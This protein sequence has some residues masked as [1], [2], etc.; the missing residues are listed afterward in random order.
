LLAAIEAVPSIRPREAS[1]V[2]GNLTE[3]DDEDIVEAV[4]EALAAA[5]ETYLE[6]EDEGDDLFL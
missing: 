4:H 5:E 1:E 3:S 2:L 6:D